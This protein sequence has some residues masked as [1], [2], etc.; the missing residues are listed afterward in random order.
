MYAYDR[1]VAMS[2]NPVNDEKVPLV[3]LHIGKTRDLCLTPTRFNPA[4]TA[5]DLCDVAA[6][7][8]SLIVIPYESSQSLRTYFAPES[9]STDGKDQ[10]ILLIPYLEKTPEMSPLSKGTSNG[11]VMASSF[12]KAATAASK[13]DNPSQASTKETSQSDHAPQ[14]EIACTQDCRSNLADS[15]IP[16]SNRQPKVNAVPIKL[17]CHTLEIMRGVIND[18]KKPA[19]KTWAS[20]CGILHSNNPVTNKKR[21]CELLETCSSTGSTL[22][23]SL[24]ELLTNKLND[25]SVKLELTANCQPHSLTAAQ[26]KRDLVEFYQNTYH[27]STIIDFLVLH[28][29]GHDVG[30]TD[31]HIETADIPTTPATSYIQANVAKSV[32]KSSSKRNKKHWKKLK[33]MSQLVIND[34]IG[35][36]LTDYHHIRNP[37]RNPP[38]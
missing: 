26:R 28:N 27:E 17:H 12:E 23:L 14:S 21:L 16:I 1:S 32:A 19:L 30:T 33:N 25:R 31:T 8:F 34:P 4:I 2:L 38:V 20:K 7:N 35:K 24:L 29:P 22:A 13:D 11:P 9:A 15:A 3:A 10:Q 18:L 6:G 37:Q 5:T 36:Y